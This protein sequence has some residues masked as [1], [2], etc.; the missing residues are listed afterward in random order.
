M[1]VS[2]LTNFCIR[3]FMDLSLERAGIWGLKSH[4]TVLEKDVVEGAVPIYAHGFPP[5][6]IRFH[7]RRDEERDV[8]EIADNPH[9]R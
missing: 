6:F 7:I 4:A 8:E 5:P 2:T 9:E 3:K 1:L